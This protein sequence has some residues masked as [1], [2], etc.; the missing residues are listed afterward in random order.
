[1]IAK[2]CIKNL[3]LDCI[4]GFKPYEREHKQPVLITLA[5]WTDI[6]DAIASD[7]VTDTV[8]YSF[9]RGDVMELVEKSRYNLFES[10]AYAIAQKVLS[11]QQ[12]QKVKVIVE[13]I[14]TYENARCVGV[15]IEQERN[16]VLS[17]ENKDNISKLSSRAEQCLTQQHCEVEGSSA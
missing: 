12:I 11:Y 2:I 10:L 4:I 1:M 3:R 13:K 14:Q 5:W 15:E 17:L 8:S 6:A 7:A 9:I 16:F